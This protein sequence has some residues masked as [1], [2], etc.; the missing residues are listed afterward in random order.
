M[1]LRTFI[2]A[3]IISKRK[4]SVLII[5]HRKQLLE[6]WKERLTAFLKGKKI[7]IGIL[8]GEQNRFPK[9]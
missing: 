3:N 5:V 8:G 1:T 9:P 2:A 6:Q 4:I 7:K